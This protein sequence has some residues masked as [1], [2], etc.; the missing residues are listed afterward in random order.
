MNTRDSDIWRECGRIDFAILMR[1]VVGKVS[2]V[3]RSQ[4]RYK[5]LYY[6]VKES[7]RRIACATGYEFLDSRAA[8]L[9]TSASDI[10]SMCPGSVLPDRNSDAILTMGPGRTGMSIPLE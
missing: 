1:C 5:S 9:L 10:T 7:H 8:A 6:T 3:C 2:Q 4:V